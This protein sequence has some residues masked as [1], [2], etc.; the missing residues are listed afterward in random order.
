MNATVPLLAVL[1]ALPVTLFGAQP[2]LHWDGSQGDYFGDDDG[3]FTVGFRFRA[4]TDFAV[5]ALGAFDYLGDGFS[6][7]HTIGLWD[8]ASGSLMATATV[9]PGTGAPLVGQ[10][11]Y[12]DVAGVTLAAN[13]EYIVAASEFY[14]STRDL[15]A[16][17][18]AAAF[19]M[20][21]GL[22]YLAPR[23]AAEAPGLVFPEF[24]IGAPFS[25]V[26]GAN[27]Q[28][29]A[30]PEPSTCVLFAA[31]LGWGGAVWARSRRTLNRQVAIRVSGPLTPN[32]E[33]G[34]QTLDGQRQDFWFRHDDDT[35]SDKCVG[36]EFA[37]K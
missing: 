7:S 28:V 30:V 24:E 8:V 19:T 35:G 37:L 26:F 34:E 29:T 33:Q 6:Q 15:Y 14:G 27:L 36:A 31:G 25:G 20:A 3:P 10:F 13:R 23:S 4:E 18:P 12:M 22:S 16:S 17:V 9:T 5:T 32:S 2:G 11:R 1:A 21:P